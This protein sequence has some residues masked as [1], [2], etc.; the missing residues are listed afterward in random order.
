MVFPT[1]ESFY[2]SVHGRSPFLWQVEMADRLC[3]DKW[4]ETISLP[5]AAGKTAILTIWYYALACTL[6]QGNRTVPLRLFFVVNRRLLID[7]V[8]KDH[9]SKLQKALEKDTSLGIIVDTIRKGLGIATTSPVLTLGRMRGGLDNSESN[10]WC[11][12][13]SYLPNMP[14]IVTCSIDQLGSRLLFRGYGVSSKGRSIHAALVG[15]DSFIVLDEAHLAQPLFETLKRIIPSVGNISSKIPA[16]RVMQMSATAQGGKT[17][18]L[19]KDK[20]IADRL[21]ARRPIRLVECEATEP[22]AKT[23]KQEVLTL[24]ENESRKFIVAIC[25]TVDSAR[26]LYSLFQAKGMPRSVLFTGRIR[27]YEK[28]KLIQKYLLPDKKGNGGLLVGR[29]RTKC[30]PIVLITTQTIEVG[31]N[32]DADG[33]VSESAPLDCLIQRFGRM[34]RV[35]VFNDCQGVVVFPNRWFKEQLQSDPVYGDLSLQTFNFLREHSQDDFIGSLNEVPMTDESCALLFTKSPKTVTMKVEVLNELVKT[36]STSDINLDPYLHGIIDNKSASF[37]LVYR[38]EI[39]YRDLKEA[40]QNPK[41]ATAIKRLLQMTSV[42]SKERL[43][44]P[45]SILYRDGTVSDYEEAPAKIAKTPDMRLTNYLCVRKRDYKVIRLGEVKKGDEVFVPVEFGR[46]DEYGWNEACESSATDVFDECQPK[47]LRLHPEFIKNFD[48]NKC[49]KSQMGTQRL[50]SRAKLFAH[51]KKVDPAAYTRLRKLWVGD[52]TRIFTPDHL[53][54][55]VYSSKFQGKRV[56][57][58]L[59]EHQ[60]QAAKIVKNV[61]EAFGFPVDLMK[62]MVSAMALHDIGKADPRF[63]AMLCYPKPFDST[64][65]LAKSGSSRSKKRVRYCP[66][67]WRH[68]LQS[69][70]MIIENNLDR[71]PDPALM[72]HLAGSHHGYMR[73]T[74]K[75]VFDESFRP[76]TYGKYKSSKPY[77]SVVHICGEVHELGERYGHW[78]LA[79]L[80]TIIRLGDYGASH[81]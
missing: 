42:A 55:Y 77:T 52:Y 57:Q 22:L 40:G 16:S 43:N 63:Q 64:V 17:F 46:Y 33:M 9:A 2:R 39:N 47:V 73:P 72:R 36:N 59:E 56:A 15:I 25:N 48:L 1:F 71:A 35:G 81:V 27:E 75:P 8:F 54:L 32:L 19:S 10:R 20:N 49:V 61:C 12:G 3:R 44:L 69:L 50:I 7:D 23:M 26:K 45:M 78:V 37:S 70:A 13:G 76:F 67:G 62:T 34:N 53:G 11:V 5:T 60:M 66:V 29:D 6:F 79:F 74:F 31:I 38:K 41:K 28:E 4:D 21:N 58:N 30:E 65:F 18:D 51:V 14:A 68:E 24:L 80:E